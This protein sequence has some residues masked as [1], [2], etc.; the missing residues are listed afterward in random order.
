MQHATRRG[1]ASVSGSPLTKVSSMQRG[2]GSSP[3]WSESKADTESSSTPDCSAHH[4]TLL[5]RVLVA[6]NWDCRTGHG[7]AWTVTQTGLAVGR[8]PSA[9]VKANRSYI[10]HFSAC[11]SSWLGGGLRR[12]KL[13]HTLAGSVLAPEPWPARHSSTSSITVGSQIRCFAALCTSRTSHLAADDIEMGVDVRGPGQ[14]H[15][16]NPVARAN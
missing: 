15:S 7:R 14:N 4:Q 13:E 6:S 12:P 2:E 3:H 10:R 16:P 8:Q 5:A 9:K 11:R 1:S